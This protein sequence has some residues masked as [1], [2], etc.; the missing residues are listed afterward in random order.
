MQGRVP[1]AKLFRYRGLHS[2]Q[3]L[4]CIHNDTK[5]KNI[6]LVSMPPQVPACTFCFTQDSS[7]TFTAQTRLL[8]KAW[9]LFPLR[10]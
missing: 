9:D 4:I 6:F 8:L 3:S 7:P 1:D 5:Q 10:F 2:N